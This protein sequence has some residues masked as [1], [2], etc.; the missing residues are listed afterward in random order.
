MNAKS[1]RGATSVAFVATL[2]ELLIEG[3]RSVQELAEECGIDRNT[4]GRYLR[5]LRRRK[6]TFWTSY[7]Q[8]SRGYYTIN[9]PQ[10]AIAAGVMFDAPKP[11]TPAGRRA[12]IR[13]IKRKEKAKC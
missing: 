10:L 5:T 2:I 4:M 3:G 11:L 7:K 6:L 8:D 9:C 13:A 12:R 1:P